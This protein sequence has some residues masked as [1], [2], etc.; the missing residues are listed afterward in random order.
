[1]CGIMFGAY[2]TNFAVTHSLLIFWG[3]SES[4]IDA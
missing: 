1:M 2:S 3:K 4:V